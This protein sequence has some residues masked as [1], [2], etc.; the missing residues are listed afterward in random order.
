MDSEKAIEK[1]LNEAVKK[2]GGW[3]IKLLPFQFNGLPDR[4]LLIP[5]GHVIFVEVKSEKKKPEPLQLWVHKKLRNLGFK[6]YVIDTFEL[7]NKLMYDIQ[8]ISVSGFHDQTHNR[9]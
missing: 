5:G 6:V 8:T 7:L 2:L 4:L 3:S 9:E 1:K